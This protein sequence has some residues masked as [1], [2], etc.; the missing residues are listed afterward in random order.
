MQEMCNL[1]N[2]AHAMKRIFLCTAMIGAL[3][4]QTGSLTL[5]A[6]SLTLQTGSAWAAAT[7]ALLTSVKGEASGSTGALDSH[8]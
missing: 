5:Q 8:T 7:N 2:G 1:R 6:G 3:T 4:L